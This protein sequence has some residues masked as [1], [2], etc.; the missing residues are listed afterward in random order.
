MT[1][2]TT[3]VLFALAGASASPTSVD[4]R[5][6]SDARHKVQLEFRVYSDEGIGW[7]GGQVRYRQSK[8]FIPLVF[9]HSDVLQDI[10]GRPS[11][12]EHRW[13]EVVDGA[14]TGEY[15]LTS[16]G[17]NVYGFRYLN[18]KTGK[19]FELPEQSFPDEAGTCRW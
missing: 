14:I 8:E 5:C 19:A 9:Q 2:L 4:T 17:A 10:E 7:V 11:E 15:R 16:Q 12:F 13:L 6:F 3:F 18:R 1:T